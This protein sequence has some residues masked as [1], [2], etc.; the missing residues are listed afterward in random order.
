MSSLAHLTVDLSCC[1]DKS[2]GKLAF[3]HPKVSSLVL[4]E[5]RLIDDP[6]EVTEKA[7]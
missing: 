4:K 5:A 6:V 2:P 3:S 7:S 1:G